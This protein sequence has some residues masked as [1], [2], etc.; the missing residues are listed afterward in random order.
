MCGWVCC[1]LVLFEKYETSFKFAV[2]YRRRLSYQ[3]SIAIVQEAGGGRNQAMASLLHI[4]QSLTCWFSVA[5][6]AML[7]VLLLCE[8]ARPGDELPLDI[9]DG[10]QCPGA[11]DLW[12]DYVDPEFVFWT[13]PPG[14]K[15]WSIDYRIQQMF[16]SRTSRQFGTAPQFGGS[17]YAPLSK[18]DWSL[19]S[20]WTGLRFGVREPNWDI[21]FEWLTTL[22][23]EVGGNMK[24]FDWSGPDRDPASLSSSPERWNDGQ[25]IEIEADYKLLGK[26]FGLPIE[27]WPLVGFRFQRF[28]MMA[29]NG[30]QLINDGTLGPDVPDVGYRWPDIEGSMNQQYYIG[31]AG[32][33]FRT[34]IEHGDWSPITLTLQADYGATAGYG[35]D[36]HITGYEELGIHRFSMESTRGDAAHIAFI[37]EVHVTTRGTLGLQADHTEIS[38]SGSHHLVISDDA[39][40]YVD[41]TWSN[42]VSVSSRQT[43]L[44]AFF[45][46]RI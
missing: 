45:N 14:P 35:I 7:L 4:R 31:Y 13:Q 1:P 2:F 6:G 3:R 32:V 29:H 25:K 8:R 34:T 43:S 27:M 30:V 19:N 44:T 20:T 5:I 10:D 42:G 24:D 23:E 17:Q 38:A 28:D 37:V 39:G 11:A 46:L 18:L 15:G 12:K 26:V 9:S 40:R 21:H 36:H 33:Q 22:V 41:E 16:S